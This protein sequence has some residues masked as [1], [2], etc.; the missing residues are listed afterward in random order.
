[1]NKQ[2]K[3]DYSKVEEVN[4]E[5]DQEIAIKSSLFVDNRNIK[6][7]QEDYEILELLGEG[8]FGKVKKVKHKPSGQI[9]ALKIIKRE[10]FKQAGS[11]EL[12]M[13]EIEVLKRL[14]IG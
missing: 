11:E 3:E 13:R 4:K 8:A 1:M 7:L 12:L 9:R 10:S 5:N 14:V 2:Y 6:T